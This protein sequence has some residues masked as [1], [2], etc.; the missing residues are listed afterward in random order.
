M[1]VNSTLKD[2]GNLI[3]YY[4]APCQNYTTLTESWRKIN[5][6]RGQVFSSSLHC[7]NSLAVSQIVKPEMY[8]SSLVIIF[9]FR[10]DGTDSRVRLVLNLQISG[11]VQKNGFL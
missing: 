2:L 3:L 7:D 6:T 5:K 1:M 9:I 11:M 4:L 8:L 10:L